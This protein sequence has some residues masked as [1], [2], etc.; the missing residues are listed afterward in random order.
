MRL[1]ENR[2][3]MNV[4]NQFNN[5]AVARNQQR[6]RPRVIPALEGENDIELE[7]RLNRA[8]FGKFR[9][10]I[11]AQRNLPAP[12]VYN[13]VLVEGESQID[14]EKRLNNE[15]VKAFRERRKA[16]RQAQQ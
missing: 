13:R 7:R 5:R 1:D 3:D 8:F 10:K 6:G 11:R 2:I 12:K 16:Q 9:N 15:R 4:V 14:R